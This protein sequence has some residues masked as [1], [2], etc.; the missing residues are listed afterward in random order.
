VA[1][2]V[3]LGL[4]GGPWPWWWSLALMVV[5]GLDGGPWPWWWS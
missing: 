3:V 1:L 5:R 4:D 2:M